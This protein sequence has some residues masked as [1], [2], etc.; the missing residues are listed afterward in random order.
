MKPTTEIRVMRMLEQM[1]AA[2]P[3]IQR[4]VAVYEK[5]MKA[6]KD[7]QFKKASPQFKNV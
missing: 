1:R 5:K 4:Q 6:G 3:E 7:N 2:M